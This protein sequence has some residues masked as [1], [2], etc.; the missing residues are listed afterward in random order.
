MD[1]IQ[2][3]AAVLIVFGFIIQ[4]LVFL[5]EQDAKKL[6]TSIVVYTLGFVGAIP[7]YGRVFGW[8]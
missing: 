6:K 4:S 5:F 3:Y 1:A 8:W 7:I 2:T